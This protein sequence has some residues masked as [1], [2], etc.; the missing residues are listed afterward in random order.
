[1]LQHNTGA[2]KLYKGLGFEV[3]Q[4]IFSY[5]IQN[6]DDLQLSAI[7]LSKDYELKHS[8]GLDNGFE[9]FLGFST[10]MAK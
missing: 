8:I 9:D 7:T 10:L 1:M 4:K 3:A 2:Y 5:S 6:V